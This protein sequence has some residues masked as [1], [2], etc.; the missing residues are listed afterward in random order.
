MKRL[1]VFLLILAIMIVNFNLSSYADDELNLTAKSAILID[2]ATGDILYDKKSSEKM[3]P[4]STTKI[5]T[6]IIAIE[7]SDLSDLVTIDIET[8]STADGSHIALEP[9]EV[10][11]MD[12]LLHA[13]LVT[14]ANDAATAIAKYISGSVEDF[15]KL[16]NKEATKMG[17]KNS[18]FLNPNGLP[19]DDHITTA[20]DLAMI[21]KYAMKN[22]TFREIVKKSKYTI[23]PTNKKSEARVLSS[24]NKL[25]TS[26]QKINVGENSTSI[27]YNGVTGIKTGYTNAAQQCLVSG[28][29]KS[30]R[31][32]ISVVLHSIGTNVYVDT[33]KLFNYAHKNSKPILLAKKNEFIDNIAIK[34]GNLSFIT[35]V[36]ATDFSLDSNV[37]NISNIKKEFITQNNLKLPISKGQ[38]IGKV[39]FKNDDEILGSANIIS[40]SNVIKVDTNFIDVINYLVHTWWFWL[41][42]S[43]IVLRITIGI[44]RIMHRAKRLKMKKTRK[45]R[46]TVS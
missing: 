30:D 24:S 8:S 31:E 2:S 42:A 3:F 13:L 12:D 25:L 16:M 28:V 35:A 38:V 9:G 19:N 27:K 6:A 4:A 44:K 39:N 14:S 46:Q 26:E 10:L 17:A 45:K 7:N 36:F 5:L 15:A 18:N 33:H 43:L 23:E 21:A 41:V 32:Y 22:D 37:K 34:G 20:Y 40:D 29:I 1:F 11:S